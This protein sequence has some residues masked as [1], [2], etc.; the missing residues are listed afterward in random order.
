MVGGCSVNVL[1]PTY[2]IKLCCCAMKPD[3]FLLIN[4]IHGNYSQPYY[5][6]IIWNI[7]GNLNADPVL[8]TTKTCHFIM[9]YI[10]YFKL[11]RLTAVKNLSGSA[12]QTQGVSCNQ[13]GV[14][15]EKSVARRVEEIDLVLS[16]LPLCWM[17]QMRF[18]IIH[19]TESL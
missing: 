4:Y 15:V 18:W 16:T 14:R 9:S 6:L 12:C 19:N 1:F 5:D 10:P 11:N 2:Q 13:T 17:E 8:L 7:Y 3:S